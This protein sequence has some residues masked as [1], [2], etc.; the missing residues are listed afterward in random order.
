MVAVTDENTVM[1]FDV[2]P[3]Q[4]HDAPHL[5]PLLD[6]VEKRLPHLD[7]VVADKAYA[8]GPQIDAGVDRDLFPQVPKKSNAIDPRPIEKK[9]YTERNTVERPIG[10]AKQYRRIATRYEKLTATFKGFLSLAFT[11]IAM[12]AP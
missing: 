10:K 2:V 11:M 1:A 4:A 6:Q 5:E 7:E 8:G 9:A 3:G 12:K